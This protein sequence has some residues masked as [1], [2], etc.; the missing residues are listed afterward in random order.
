MTNRREISPLIA[1]RSWNMRSDPL[2]WGMIVYGVIMFSL[3]LF[4]LLKLVD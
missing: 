2:V 1:Q 3:M 4:I